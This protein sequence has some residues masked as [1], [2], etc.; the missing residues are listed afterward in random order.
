VTTYFDSSA[1]VAIYVT[2]PFSTVA[3]REARSVRQIAYTPL[4]ALEVPNALRA[5]HG[6]N[7]ITAQ[8][9]GELIVQLESDLEAQRLVETRLDLFAVFERATELSRVYTVRLLCR[10]LDILHVAAAMAVGC[11]R[12]LS[13]DDR[14]LALARAIG[15]EAVDVKKTRQ[16]R[17]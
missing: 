15:L 1:L 11:Q 5:L 3:R 6:R 14:Q 9:L 13:G 7:L 10:S 2:E 16:R 4:H 8:E 17:G 12:L